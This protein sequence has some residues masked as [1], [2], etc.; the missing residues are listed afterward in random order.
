MYLAQHELESILITG[1]SI[2][3]SLEQ[4]SLDT[5]IMGSMNRSR[6]TEAAQDLP[7]KGEEVGVKP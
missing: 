4:S 5:E 6:L 7:A 2:Y 3:L 1:I